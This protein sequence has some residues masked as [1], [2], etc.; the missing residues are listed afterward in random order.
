MLLF[1]VMVMIGDA[2]AAEP[3]D[4]LL[5]VELLVVVG[6][7]RVGERVELVDL[8]VE[9]IS[10]RRFRGFHTQGFLRGSSCSLNVFVASRQSKCGGH[11]K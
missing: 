8:R 5:H 3:V 2:P 7:P 1:C 10:F 6:N 9:N 4:V 11:E